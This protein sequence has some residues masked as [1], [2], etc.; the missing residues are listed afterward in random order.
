MTE[1]I[2]PFRAPVVMALL[3][4]TQGCATTAVAD[5]P[6]GPDGPA[7]GSSFTEVV[8]SVI[9]T[10]P[11]DRT[12][13][14]IEV[15]DATSDRMILRHN[16]DRHFIPA[17][18]QKIVTMAAAAD[19][20]G[21]DYRYETR[22]TVEAL[23]EGVA[24]RIIVQGSGDPTLS[25]HFHDS[26]LA[27]L[28][29][30][31]DSLVAAGLRRVAGP[32]VVD[33]SRF[34]STLAH[35]AWEHFDL[36]WY[37]A[38]PVAAFAVAE[39]AIPVAVRPTVVGEPARVDVLLPDGIARID[40]WITTVEG[41]R[42][43]DDELRRIAALD[44][45]VLRGTVGVAADPDTS[46]IAQIDPG[47]FAGR[48]LSLALERR[49]VAVTGPVVV[50]YGPAD[51]AAPHDQTIGAT[52]RSPPLIELVQVSLERSD[53]WLTEQV[54]KTLGAELGDGGGWSAGTQV[55]ETY[56]T[57]T[58]GIPEGA[59]YMRDGSGLTAQNL[60]TPAAMVS[61]L[62]HVSGRPWGAAFRAAMAEPG[63]VDTT[64]E[65][66]LLELEGRLWA[67][68][69]TIRHVNTLSGYLRTDDGRDLVFSILTNASGRP[70]SEM[71]RAIDRIVNAMTP[72]GG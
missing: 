26:H 25:E 12:Y 55:V 45:V 15:Y 8:D 19:L 52:W 6:P 28:D 48:A 39:G 34:D 1:M 7:A 5:L 64:L 68:T 31:A 41:E 14:G 18:N 33:Q 38:A 43:W 65:E 21:P 50:R 49:G 24:R 10:P 20:L 22:I 35:P 57:G 11:L 62:R 23:E 40:A 36:D 27:A 17:S 44:S 47:T 60:V 16:A 67:K 61:L 56:L 58:V 54:L 59:V 29:S 46:W 42:G 51:A 37:Y 32:V 70:A 13:W 72:S 69:G 53:N 71:R 4:G 63:E 9:G 2:R 30:M 3:A 66:R